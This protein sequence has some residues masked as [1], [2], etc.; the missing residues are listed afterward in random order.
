[1]LYQLSYLGAGKNRTARKPRW[2]VRGSN[3][4]HRRCKRRALPTELTARCTSLE[5]EKEWC[6]GWDLNPYG[7]WIPH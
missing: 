7:E 3:P 1:M 4:R 5:A 2:A 6:R